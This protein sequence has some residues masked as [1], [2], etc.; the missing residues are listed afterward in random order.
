V[1]LKAACILHCMV[2]VAAQ[3]QQAAAQRRSLLSAAVAA[4]SAYCARVEP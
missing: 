2:F 3:R 4:H 1:G